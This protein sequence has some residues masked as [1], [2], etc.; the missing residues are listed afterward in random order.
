MKKKDKPSM[1][2]LVETILE[3]RDPSKDKPEKESEE[4]EMEEEDEGLPRQVIAQDLI[5]ALRSGNPDGVIAALDAWS[6]ASSSGFA[7]SHRDDD[8]DCG[9]K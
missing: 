7:T 8:P 4:M 3:K 6:Q 5:D 2:I 9:C 1:G